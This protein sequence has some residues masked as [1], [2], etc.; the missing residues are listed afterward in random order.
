MS[1]PLRI[2][3][4]QSPLAL[5]QAKE[6]G[7]RLQTLDPD[8]DIEL[9]GMTT[10][11]DKLL[12]T[13]LSK[14]GGKGLFVKELEVG[15]MEDR[16]DI[17]VHSVKDVPMTFPPGL[18]MPVI[19]ER[20]DPLDALVSDRYPTLDDMPDDAIVGTSSLRRQCQLSAA[21]PGF[22]V[23][24]LRGNVNTR[25]AKLDAGD[26]DG[27]IL[28]AIGLERLG[29]GARIATRLSTEQS[30]PA[31]GQGALGVECAQDNARINELLAPL[32][33]PDTH[34]RIAAER[35]M[36]K[37]LS[38]GCSV[39]VAGYAELDG[40][41]LRL[42]GLVGDPDGRRMVRGEVTGELE[43]HPGD[44]VKLGTALAEE[45]LG[46]GADSILRDLGVEIA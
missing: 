27:I 14:V 39:P 40:A 18:H 31:I 46:T 11:G 33:H 10:R 20:A 4:R 19:L 21:H 9:V 45:L 7:R 36:N 32:N 30:L 25:L 24:T 29:F 42:R 13:P 41:T 23:T 17:A 2:A 16:A 3:T 37:R 6:V 1:K 35:A 5:W 34:T 22:R 43:D 15:L 12:G 8:L 38:G 26:Y 28:A 44:A